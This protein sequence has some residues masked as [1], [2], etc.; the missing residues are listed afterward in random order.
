MSKFRPNQTPPTPAPAE[1]APKEGNQLPSGGEGF[2]SRIMKLDVGSGVQVTPFQFDKI[3]QRSE[4]DYGAVKKKY[5]SLAA[6]DQD[7]AAKTKKDARF[8]LNPVLRDRLSVEEEERRAIDEKVRSR[9]TALAEEAKAK[10]TAQGY[11][12]GYQKG[13][14]EAYAKLR[15]E[16]AAR[17][18]QFDDFLAECE[19]AKI[20]IYQANERFLV[21]LVFRIARMITLKEVKQDPDY[22]MKLAR[23]I[24]ERVGVRENVRI[25]IHPEEMATA[26]VIRE[27]L[28]KTLGALKNLNIEP[29]SQVEL[30]GCI[31][32]T[33]WNAID[34]SIET[35]L[36]G[37]Y[38]SLVGSAGSLKAPGDGA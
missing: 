18:K 29:S 12:E 15:E 26:S 22:V 28:E 23:D 20:E 14:D 25:R 33:E 27:G 4:G 24:L 38:E 37:V 19:R 11:E 30:G 5:G 31:V 7:R 2:K 34:A 8:A 10:S 32:E 1:G 9:V 36:K 13:H 3:S 16:G 35:Q 6:T 21:E 17:L